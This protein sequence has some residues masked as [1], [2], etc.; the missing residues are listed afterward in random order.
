MLL[1]TAVLAIMTMWVPT[2][3]LAQRGSGCLGHRP[4]YIDNS[5]EVTYDSGCSGHDE[6]ELD[7]V[8]SLAGSA[9]D[10][11]WT[12]VLPSDGAFDVSATGPTFWFGGTV[13]DPNSLFGQA[14]V[15]LQFYPDSI[16][17]HCSSNGGFNVNY[18]PNTYSACSPVWKLTSTGRKGVFHESAAFNAMLTDGSGR[19]NP[20]IMHAGDTVTVHWYTTPAQDGFHV[21]VTDVSTGGS[22]TIVLNSQQ[23][24][25]LMPAYDTQEIG[26]S[27]GWGIV[28]DTPN[29]FVWEIGHTS[30][31]TKPGSQF[32]VPGQTNC[33]SYDA[34]AWAGTSPIQIQSVTFAD[35]SLAGTYAV[36]SDYGGKAEVN[37]YCSSYGGP[38]CIYPWYSLGSSGFH[39]GVDFPDNLNDFG[40]AD[41]FP[42]TTECGGPFG[43]NTTYCANVLP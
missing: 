23:D 28:Y 34:D 24:G 43:Q 9:R 25:P 3:A 18:S 40:Q 19:N 33:F 39:Y 21:T 41:Q 32:C 16:V 38:F 17:S 42:Q 10:L 7:P 14:F 35:G 31:F 29:S 37:Q 27:L 13:T 22:G 4:Q 12:V 6:P 26:N 36:V 5:F 8:S 1:Y 30:P 20:L 15:E 2:F 11:T